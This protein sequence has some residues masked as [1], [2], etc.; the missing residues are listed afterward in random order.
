[1]V[2]GMANVSVRHPMIRAPLERW[3]PPDSNV[4]RE[5]RTLSEATEPQRPQ[6]ATP[7]VGSS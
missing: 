4:A 7:L 3:L 1:M 5:T 2:V 6:M